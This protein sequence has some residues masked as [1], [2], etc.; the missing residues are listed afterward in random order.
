[1][2]HIGE[3]VILEDPAYVH[4]TALLYGKVA[5]KPGA[6]IFAH[7]VMRA[8]AHEIVVGQR[9]NIQDFAMISVGDFTPTLIGEDC[10]ITTRVALRGCTIGN[11]CLIGIG[12]TILDG[13]KIGQ[14]SIVAGHAM[15]DKNSIF[16]PNSIIA[17]VPAKK[18]GERDNSGVTRLNSSIY[19]IASENYAAGAE[20]F[21][22]A[23]LQSIFD[24]AQANLSNQ[25]TQVQA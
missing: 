10:S 23:Q 15:V 22:D 6:S 4:E 2:G 11:R 18:I 16:E 20:R 24:L 7:V 13:A 1:M 3:D 21:T 25:K 17:G 14:N 12:A 8:E 9:S 5:I 19:Q